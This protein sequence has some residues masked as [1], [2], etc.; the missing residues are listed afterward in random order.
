MQIA[1]VTMGILVK[2]SSLPNDLELN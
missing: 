1:N 2:M